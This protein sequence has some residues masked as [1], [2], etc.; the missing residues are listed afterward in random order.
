MSHDERDLLPSTTVILAAGG[1]VWEGNPWESRIGLI[2]RSRYGD[3]C[4][5]KGKLGPGESF[6]EAAVREVLEETGR[7]ATLG[8]FAGVVHYWVGESP[9][10]VL[11]W[12]MTVA[13]DEGFQ[14][15]EEVAEFSWFTVPA[16]LQRLDHHAERE[17]LSSR[18]P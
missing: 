16:A 1:L 4:L 14:P 7:R 9:K 18:S 8:R 10:V 15:G 2:H 5:P 6:E 13:E 3:W 17:L 11:F 12:H